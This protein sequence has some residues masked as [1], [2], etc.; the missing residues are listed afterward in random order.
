[1]L[2][3]LIKRARDNGQINGM[4]Q[5]PVDRGLSILQYANDTIFFMKNDLEK[6][7]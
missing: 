3:I 1:M 5:H 7:V 6:S 4:V 2:A